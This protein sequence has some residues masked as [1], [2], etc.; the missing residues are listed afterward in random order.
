MAQLRHMPAAERSSEGPIENQK[1]ELLAPEVRQVDHV[2]VEIGQAE[3]R[4]DGIKRH[5]WHVLLRAVWDLTLGHY[6]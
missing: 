4:S 3:V 2:A 6:Q 5:S 1:D